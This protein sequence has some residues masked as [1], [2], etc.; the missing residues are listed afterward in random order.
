MTRGRTLRNIAI[1]LAL[2]ALY[3]LVFRTKL[4]LGV[5]IVVFAATATAWDVLGG[6]AGQLSLGHAALMGVGGYTMALLSL[7][8]GLAPWW[9]LILGMAL[10]AVVAAGWGWMVFRLRGPYF[11]LSTIAVAE[12]LRLVAINWTSFTGGAEGLFIKQLP[13]PFGLDLFN[14]TVE[15]YMGLGWLAVAL[16]VAWWLSWSK[17]GYYLQAIR[18][19]QDS[20][21]AMGIN[22]TRYKILA[23]MVSAALTAAGGA[24]FALYVSFFEPHIIFDIGMSVEL[25]LMAYIGGAGTIFGPA[26]GAVVLL[27]AGDVFRNYFQQANLLIYGVLI[28]LI[29]R[30]APEGIVGGWQFLARRWPRGRRIAAQPAE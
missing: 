5:A 20:A 10:S 1:V 26:I 30:F 13:Q 8:A 7:R 24:L 23:F 29:V 25:A 27:G 22:P 28:I 14:R 11:A 16:L 19:D 6:W 21:M 18:E 17:F 3:P 2:L 12:I 15:F 4:N 9:G